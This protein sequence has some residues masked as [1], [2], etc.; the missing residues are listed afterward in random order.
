MPGR[1]R[2]VYIFSAS[3]S[4]VDGGTTPGGESFRKL[5]SCDLHPTALR[6]GLDLKPWDGSARK[7]EMKLD[8][9]SCEIQ[10]DLAVV[11]YV[12]AGSN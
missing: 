3:T 5:S 1:P 4:G 8:D 7:G 9:C 6:V 12:M 11:S 10:Y 2:Q